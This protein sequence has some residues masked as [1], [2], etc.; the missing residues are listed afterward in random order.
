MVR[1]AA[2]N[3]PDN[4]KIFVS[5]T[6]IY[7]IG[8]K[9]AQKILKKCNIDPHKHT[10]DLTQDEISRLQSYIEDKHKTEG[11]LRQEVKDNIRRLKSIKCYRGI[12][13]TV[14]LPVRG[15]RTRSN[16]RTKKGR[17]LPVGGLNPKIT[18]K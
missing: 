10:K 18:K 3:I 7:G 8:Q 12:R 9:Q 16:A 6:Y 4:K 14:G 5:L 2:V 11:A 1:L 13:H 15:Q 17:A